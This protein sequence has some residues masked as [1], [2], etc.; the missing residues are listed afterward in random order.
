M[1]TSMKT[2][3]AGLALSSA[4][5]VATAPADAQ[6]WRGGGGPGWGRG[7]YGGG[8]VFRGGGWRGGYR[9][10]YRGYYRPYYRGYDRTGV[11]IG[12]G[13]L[14]L[15]VGAAIASANRPYYDGYY[16]GPA[17][18]GGGYAWGGGCYTRRVW[19]P[20]IGRRVRVRYCD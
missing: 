5:V 6:R 15:G 16:G 9:G 20:Y 8:P 2:F 11:A 19:D 18:Y 1:R 17:Y 12:A 13:L 14:G 4:M 10:G 7:Y 3:V